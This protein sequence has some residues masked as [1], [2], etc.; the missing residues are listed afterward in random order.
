MM[1]LI[2]NVISNRFPERKFAGKTIACEALDRNAMTTTIYD[3]PLF[4]GPSSRKTQQILSILRNSKPRG[5]FLRQKIAHHFFD[6]NFFTN[7]SFFF[8]K[9]HLNFS[10]F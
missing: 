5:K 9:K 3:S 7:E 8:A 2:I 1:M 6:T 10:F 4:R